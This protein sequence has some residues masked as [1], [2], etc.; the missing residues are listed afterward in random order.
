MISL[1]DGRSAAVMASIDTLAQAELFQDVSRE[2]LERVVGLAHTIRL[3]EGED[4]YRLGDPAEDLFVLYGGRVRF[5]L[6]VANRPESA[7]S[8]IEPTTVFGWAALLAD[9][10]RRVATAV[11]LEDSDLYVISGSALLQLCEQDQVFGYLIMR[12]LATMIT[13]DFLAVLSV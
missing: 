7:N 2:S 3:E 8:L 4:V 11:C 12:R 13:R 5:S 6:G 9:Q 1:A 10:P